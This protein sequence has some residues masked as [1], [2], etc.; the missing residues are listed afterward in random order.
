MGEVL[1]VRDAV[2]QS[3]RDG[4]RREIGRCLLKD[5]RHAGSGHSD[6]NDSGRW[7]VVKI[8]NESPR[9]FA[10]DLA[11]FILQ[12]IRSRRDFHERERSNLH[13]SHADPNGVS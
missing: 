11:L 10:F 3:P 13:S 9:A 2:P 1:W 8:I 7:R 6:G 12:D 4:E 5:K